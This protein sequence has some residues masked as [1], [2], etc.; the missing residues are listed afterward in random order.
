MRGGGW[1]VLQN[2]ERVLRGEGGGG[3]QHDSGIW[4]DLKHIIYWTLDF[5]Y[6][7]NWTHIF[8]P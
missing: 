7:R 4:T 3:R 2:L 6:R 1:N 8:E 5:N